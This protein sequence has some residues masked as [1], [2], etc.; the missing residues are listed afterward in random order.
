[1][2]QVLCRCKSAFSRLS[3]T[4]FVCCI[5]RFRVI[6]TCR[7]VFVERLFLNRLPLFWQWCLPVEMW[8]RDFFSLITPRAS[9]KGWELWLLFHLKWVSCFIVIYI[10]CFIL[11]SL[12]ATS[13]SL[14]MFFIHGVFFLGNIHG[15]SVF[16]QIKSRQ[17]IRIRVCHLIYA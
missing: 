17:G 11:R 8:S 13:D 12:N 4:E 15:K 5:C 14:N 10:A 9:P 2:L 6:Y 1:M 7:S 3:E 16:W